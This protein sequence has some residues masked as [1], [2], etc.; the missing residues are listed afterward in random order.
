MTR[1]NVPVTL[2]VEAKDVAS[3]ARKEIGRVQ[4]GER[5]LLSLLSADA[6]HRTELEANLRNVNEKEELRIK[7]APPPEAPKFSIYVA[8]VNRDD[9]ELLEVVIAYMRQC[10]G[11]VLKPLEEG[12]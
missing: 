4:F 1:R 9:P 7:V 2:I 10:H 12:V 11:L 3:G 5:G 8:N 6:G